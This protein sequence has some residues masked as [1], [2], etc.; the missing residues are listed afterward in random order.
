MGNI[1]RGKKETK[2]KVA[3]EVKRVKEEKNEAQF[4]PLLC[5][6]KEVSDSYISNQ[7]TT[8]PHQHFCF[9]KGT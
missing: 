7:P 4:H 1:S 5:H 3:L 6:K 2:R 8:T 9:S